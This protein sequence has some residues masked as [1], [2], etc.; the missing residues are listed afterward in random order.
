MW[1][2]INGHSLLW[3][4]LDILER[5]FKALQTRAAVMSYINHVVLV[6]NLSRLSGQVYKYFLF[7]FLKLR[8]FVIMGLGLRMSPPAVGGFPR[9]RAL[10]QVIGVETFS[11]PRIS[12]MSCS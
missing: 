9:R 11:V 7:F 5:V 3:P 8:S 4:F 6:M 1:Q 10:S 2:G 12:A